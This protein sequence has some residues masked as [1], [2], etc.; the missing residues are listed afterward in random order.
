MADMTSPHPRRDPEST[1]AGSGPVSRSGTST[2]LSRTTQQG[3]PDGA[4]QCCCGQIGC[5]YL[6]HNCTVLESVEN[7]VRTAAKLGQSLLERHEAYMAD[8]ERDRAELFK[9][10][11]QL[12]MDKK[13]LEAENAKKIQE[14]RALLDQLET[15]NTT[16]SDSDTH[17][18]MLEASLQSSQQIIRR[19][20]GAA[21]RAED[22]ER[23]LA[24]LEAEQAT[25]QNNLITSESEAR[26]AVQR[27]KRAERGIADLQ[28]QLDV[29]EKESREEQARHKEV[30]GRMERQRAVEKE[31]NTAAG[32]LKGAAATKSL[33]DAKSSNGGSAVVSHFVRDLLQDNANLQLGMAELRDMLM[34]SNDEIQALRDQLMYHQPLVEHDAS[35]ASTLRAELETDVLPQ[36]PEPYDAGD[37]GRHDLRDP[38]DALEAIDASITISTPSTPQPGH[39]Q[40]SLSQEF[41]IHHHHYH[42]NSKKVDMKKPKKKRTGLTPTVFT[43]PSA[44]LSTPSTPLYRPSLPSLSALPYQQDALSATPGSSPP[45]RHSHHLSRDSI[46]TAMS[47]PSNRWSVF[48]DQPSD[49]SMSSVPSSPRT[50]PRNSVFDRML[51]SNASMPVSPT[52]SVDPLSPTWR[53]SSRMPSLDENQMACG[54][55]QPLSF[56][57]PAPSDQP[58]QPLPQLPEPIMEDEEYAVS[59][60]DHDVAAAVHDEAQSD[61]GHSIDDVPDFASHATGTADES[62]PSE[63]EATTP[64]P[65]QPLSFPNDDDVVEPVE[66][67]DVHFALPSR[68]HR[69]LHRAVSHESIISL[70]GGLDIH[71]L[72]T[73]PSQ[74]TLRPLGTAMAD[75]GLSSITA[76]P[77]IARAGPETLKSNNML[78]G[79]LSLGVPASRTSRVVSSPVT[80][81]TTSASASLSTVS[82]AAATLSGARKLGKYVGWRPWG[83]GGTT[84]TT[85]ASAAAPATQVA[86]LATTAAAVATPAIA[87]T[88]TAMTIAPTGSEP[89]PG[90]SQ[91]D[92]IVSGT[93]APETTRSATPIA[94]AVDVPGRNSS[95]GLS[96]AKSTVHAKSA[97]TKAMHDLSVLRSPGINQPGAIP[98]FFEYWASHQRRGV[99]S[100]VHADVVDEE[101]LREGLLGT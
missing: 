23:H 80:A 68:H 6:Q 30:M 61:T 18:K 44:T 15:L 48:S 88:T 70:Q 49:F 86:T 26:S 55:P 31:L 40:P 47:G 64:K 91:A 53:S 9:R 28:Y 20:E 46:S 87:T 54:F 45:T 5:V 90:A 65:T 71:T 19:L 12:E 100:N 14:N 2:P 33:H 3:A 25:L 37:R 42:V 95:R 8:A 97:A 74:L 58:A 13:E 50:D 82:Q 83:G 36:S 32:R 35:A 92:S 81:A 89:M 78:R 67:E 7:D 4:L 94:T 10:I 52:T 69:P 73:R 57:S 72:K 39:H 56:S 11:G 79:N 43:P 101:A 60:E 21:E 38:N 1:A 75:T 16:A 17:I 99:P 93:G 77:V 76:R 29:M 41:H 84:T 96:S 59:A 98:G 85:A 62:A 24:V 66:D 22:M 63:A 27:W 34:T 51:L